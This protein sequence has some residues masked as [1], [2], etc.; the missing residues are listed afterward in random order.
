MTI[1][2]S[3]LKV[4][5]AAKP[6][7]LLTVGG[8]ICENVPNL[9]TPAEEQSV[10]VEYASLTAPQKAVVDAFVALLKSKL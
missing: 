6:A 5:D 7:E 4:K 9:L 2:F 1:S 10:N 3:S 8:T